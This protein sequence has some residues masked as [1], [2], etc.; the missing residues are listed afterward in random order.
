[1]T[2]SPGQARDYE[3]EARR[4]A[5]A[6]ARLAIA[7]NIS[8]KA[9]AARVGSNIYTVTESYI[10]L[11]KGTPEEVAA[12]ESGA[13][14]VRS[15]VDAIRQRS[16]KQERWSQRKSGA[17]RQSPASDLVMRQAAFRAA[18]IVMAEGI[19]HAD[20]A[21]R[22]GA[23]RRSVSEAYVILANCS[24]SQI[25]RGESGET[26]IMELTEW[27]RE[28]VPAEI[29]KTKRKIARLGG[30]VQQQRDTESALWLKLRD[31]LDNIAAMPL[32]ADVVGICKKNRMREE[33]VN[34]KLIAA[35]AWITEFS[36][37]WTS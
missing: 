4:K 13:V 5:L 19:S 35:F 17:G 11:T 12:L 21:R 25:S 33:K 16:T 20:A 2:R 10:I 36:D 9:A 27:V 30:D 6:G 7:E 22:A 1:M 37:A 31:A 34:E 28:N 3:I 24:P 23:S 32:P 26:S 14:A 8:H 18:R 15:A 29:R